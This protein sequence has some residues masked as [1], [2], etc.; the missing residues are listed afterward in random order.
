VRIRGVRAFCALLAAAAIGVSC[1]Q[2]PE[3]PAVD[4]TPESRSGRLAGYGLTLVAPEGWDA[5]IVRGAVRFANR[6]LPSTR[7]PLEL[8]P[9]ELVVQVLERDAVWAAE[10]DAPELEGPPRLT[11]ADFGPPEPVTHPTQSSARL[12][13][14]IADR[15]FVLFADSGSR[16]IDPETLETANDIL[17]TLGVSRA[18]PY[19][20]EVAAPAFG[21]A[22]GWHTG[23]SGPR[24]VHPDGEWTTAWASTVP[25]LDEWDAMPTNTLSGL[26]P[27]GLVVYVAVSRFFDPDG[28]GQRS[29][30]HSRPYRLADFEVLPGWEGQIRDLPQHRLWTR[31]PG[32]YE[33]EI[34]VYFGRPDP[35]EEM[36]EGA[37]GQLDLLVLPQWGPWEL[38]EGSLG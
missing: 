31:V 20:G 3:T 9:G 19:A 5:E 35:T 26:P 23:S 10:A 12:P 13:F 14:L 18:D 34:R 32:Q 8:A 22:D 7:G 36:L 15:F 24:P 30:V 25:Y 27:D 2:S 11:A 33:V 21:Q 17:A 1:G 38:E 29:P 4:S 37:Q 6:A 28:P 16:T